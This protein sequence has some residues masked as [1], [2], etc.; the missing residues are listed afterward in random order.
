MN[1]DD[2]V[3]LLDEEE[4]AKRF[5][6]LLDTVLHPYTLT[7]APGDEHNSNDH[8]VEHTCSASPGMLGGAGKLIPDAF[9]C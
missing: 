4:A 2:A 7:A 8:V 5:H 6:N 1:R 9:A 3:D